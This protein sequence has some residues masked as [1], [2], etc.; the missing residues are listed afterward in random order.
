M[1]KSTPEEIETSLL[2]VYSSYIINNELEGITFSIRNEC[3]VIYQDLD[4][5]DEPDKYVITKQNVLPYWDEFTNLIRSI[6]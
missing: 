4:D 5:E 3:V 6:Q 2:A 1:T